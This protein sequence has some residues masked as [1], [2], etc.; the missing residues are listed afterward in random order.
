ML[1]LI[2]YT[3]FVCTTISL[4]MQQTGVWDSKL[5]Q[6]IVPIIKFFLK[7]PHQLFSSLGG[8]LNSWKRKILIFCFCLEPN[9]NEKACKSGGEQKKIDFMWGF[10]QSGHYNPFSKPPA[11]VCCPVNMITTEIS[12]NNSNLWQEHTKTLFILL[13]FP[14]FKLKHLYS[15]LKTSLLLFNTHVPSVQLR[16]YFY[17]RN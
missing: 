8:R 6:S 13:S 4:F 15:C 3:P 10:S 7:P 11:S 14:V 9:F 5:M 1:K 12:K 17:K 16:N 2:L